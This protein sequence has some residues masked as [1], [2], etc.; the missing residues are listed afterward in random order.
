MARRLPS[1]R[2]KMICMGLG[3]E[4]ALRLKKKMESCAFVV[5]LLFDRRSAEIQCG[6]YFLALID[7]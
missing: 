2:A 4:T 5:E 1:C 7:R 6:Y 3:D